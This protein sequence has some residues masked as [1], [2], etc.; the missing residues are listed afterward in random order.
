VLNGSGIA[1]QA[2]GAAQAL[3]NAGITASISGTG[4]A[5][6]FNYQTS[7]I[8]YGPGGQAGAALVQSEISGGAE[9]QADPS[10]NA[11]G[12]VLI[13]GASYLGVH[14][15]ANPTSPTTAPP[16]ASVASALAAVPGNSSDAP[17]FPGP[18]GQDPPPPGSGC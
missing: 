2:A 11:G 10:L 6:S 13:T 4:A 3:R 1:H 7:V 17:A 16:P 15:G 18:N 5:P 9:L 12:L 14:P 8:E